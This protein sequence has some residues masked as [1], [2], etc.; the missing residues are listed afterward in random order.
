MV[1]CLTLLLA[2]PQNGLGLAFAIC[3]NEMLV[4]F[5]PVSTATGVPSAT[6]MPTDLSP[7][8]DINLARTPPPRKLKETAIRRINRRL[9]DR[10]IPDSGEIEPQ[11]KM[12]CDLGVLVPSRKAR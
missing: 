4:L 1:Q 6:P 10:L 7:A 12:S 3:F 9:P 5:N 2:R 11:T 8:I